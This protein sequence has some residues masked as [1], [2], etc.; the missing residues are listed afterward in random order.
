MRG[1][2][3]VR[4][5]SIALALLIAVLGPSAARAEWRRAVSTHFIIYSEASPDDLRAT[6]ERLERFDGLL[7]RLTPSPPPDSPIRLT[8]Y[9]PRTYGAVENLLQAYGPAGFY[10]ADVSGPFAVAPRQAVSDEFSADVILFHEYMHHFMLQNYAITYPAWFVEGYAELF[11]N[12]RLERDGS[13]VIG[14]FADHRGWSLRATPPPLRDL[15]FGRLREMDAGL[16]Y[17]NAWALTHYLVISDER[18]GQLSRYIAL[19]DGGRPPA[20]A[21]DEAFTG[22]MAALERD[23][24]RYRA[25]RRIPTLQLRFADLAT[26]GPIEIQALGR[27]EEALLWQRVEYRSGGTQLA[28][29]GLLRRVRSRAQEVPGDPAALQLLA[30]VEAAGRNYPAATRAIDALLARQ[31]DAP[32][33]LLRKGLIEIAVLQRDRITDRQRWTDARQWIRRANEAAPDNP[34]I[35][36]QYYRAFEREGRQPPEPAIAALRRAFELVPQA[37]NVRAR[38]ARE[39]I[40]ARR[41]REA[42][43]VLAPIAYSAHGGPFG[44]H[45]ARIVE[46]LRTLPE[47][48]EAPADLLAPPPSDPEKERD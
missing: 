41:H 17:A 8:I 24:R 43:V 4:R 47:G 14:L 29:Q 48:T 46:R 11:S 19:V 20:Q 26:P 45:A 2:D 44:D 3:Y 35:L 21:A 15:M 40:R 13:I 33:A 31:P 25:G 22:G 12:T 42:I 39:L 36:Y 10:R 23:F 16:F 6:S 30:D 9:M 37:P 18:T 5:F 7:R 1:V 32:D 27:G 34:M 28:L 38:F